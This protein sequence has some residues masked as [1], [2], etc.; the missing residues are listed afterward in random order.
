M[1]LGDFCATCHVNIDGMK[2]LWVQNR[3]TAVYIL[4]IYIY[5]VQASSGY[6][7]VLHM[8]IFLND[9]KWFF[10]VL[11]LKTPLMGNNNNTTN[12]LNINKLC[13]IMMQHKYSLV[14]SPP[15]TKS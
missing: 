8:D 3:H 13:I 9:F 4:Y 6:T 14:K 11:I 2:P 15:N 10:S 1:K 5:T 7:M 12:I